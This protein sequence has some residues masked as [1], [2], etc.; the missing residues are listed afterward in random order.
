MRDDE[1]A[2]PA[3]QKLLEESSSAN[4][5]LQP[6]DI[7][8]LIIVDAGNPRRTVWASQKAATMASEL[9]E[10]RTIQ[11]EVYI[12]PDSQKGVLHELIRVHRADT[13]TPTVPLPLDPTPSLGRS[14][15]PPVSD[16]P[17][18]LTFFGV[19]LSY[20]QKEETGHGTKQGAKQK[21]DG[22]R[23]TGA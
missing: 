19:V 14:L 1:D 21:G 6:L 9:F 18:S 10:E 13:L 17:L 16:Q 23:S 2:L 8:D 20:I 3:I 11:R 12:A 7:N 22:L 4:D 5:D 15:L